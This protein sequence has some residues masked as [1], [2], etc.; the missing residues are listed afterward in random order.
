MTDIMI[1]RN[2]APS[3][4]TIDKL[5]I[6]HPT[7]HSFD[8]GIPVFV[9]RSDLHEVIKIDIA[10]DSGT[11][12]QSAPLAANI[13]LKMLHE[14]TKTWPGSRLST[15]LESNGA[16][17][18]HHAGKDDSVVTFLFLK[19]NLLKVLPLLESMLKEPAFSA[20]EFRILK[21]IEKEE[22]LINNEKSKHQASRLMNMKLFGENTAYGRIANVK[23]Y[24][25]LHLQDIQQH[26]ATHLGP[27]NCRIVI[28]G[29]V[30]DEILGLLNQHIGNEWN[31]TAKRSA[32]STNFNFSAGTERLSKAGALQTAIQSGRTVMHRLDENFASFLL[33]NT[34]LGGYFGSRLMSNIREDKGYTYGIYSQVNSYLH[35]TSFLIATEAGT[36]VS[37]PTLDEI[38]FEMKQLRENLVEA[39]ELELVKSYLTGSYL[40]GLDGVYN[41]AEKFRSIHAFGLNMNYY[42]TTLQRMMKTDAK[43]L[44]ELA[45]QYLN[46]DQM[47]TVLVGA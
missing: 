21:K 32:P 20:K 37:Q 3:T 15:M 47:A 16:F 7:E 11:A 1:D 40:R 36:A 34:L 33:L 39:E 23:D 43:K 42:N 44:Q 13:T 30:N 9:F 17:V 12:Q 35:A 4:Q 19:K 24:A 38:A 6:I 31:T 22:F 26:Y 27:A 46:P 14:G 18:S 41:Q 45:Q 10:F 8:N 2:I 28:S 25:S 5:N 29:P